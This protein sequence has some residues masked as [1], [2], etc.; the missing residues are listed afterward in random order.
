MFT[1]EVSYRCETVYI[2]N[3]ITLITSLDFYTIEKSNRAGHTPANRDSRK[4]LHKLPKQSR[5]KK[6]SGALDDVNI[7][8]S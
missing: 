7:S 5:F 3:K 8:Y 1:L 2:D 4:V 6:N